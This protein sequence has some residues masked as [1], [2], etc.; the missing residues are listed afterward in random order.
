MRMCR[1]DQPDVNIE[2]Y[3]LCMMDVMVGETDCC[4]GGQLEAATT[5]SGLANITILT[6]RAVFC[7]LYRSNEYYW[8]INSE[9]Y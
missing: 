8:S 4:I 7:F 6:V 5:S 2:F 9:M 3:C 1:A